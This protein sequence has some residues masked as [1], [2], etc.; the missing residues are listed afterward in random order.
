[1]TKGELLDILD[2]EH[3]DTIILV[4]DGSLRHVNVDY[5]M[6]PVGDQ[7]CSVLVITGGSV[8]AS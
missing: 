2:G 6:A 1:M 8:V 7:V 4:D 3:E 5:A